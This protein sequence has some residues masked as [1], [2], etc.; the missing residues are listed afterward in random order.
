METN[1]N[2]NTMA[3]KPLRCNKNS[4]K[5]QVQSNAGLSS[6][7]KKKKSNNLN[8]QGSKITIKHKISKRKQIINSRKKN[9]IELKKKNRADQ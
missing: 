6:R 8:L 9:D 3:Q 4:S 1:E 2:E 5:R 7:S